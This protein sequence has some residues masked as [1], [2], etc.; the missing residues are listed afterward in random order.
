MTERISETLYLTYSSPIYGGVFP[1]PYA[2]MDPSGK[3]VIT[4]TPT[5]TA[6]G[7]AYFQRLQSITQNKIPPMKVD[8]LSNSPPFDR[9]FS[10]N[11]SLHIR[12]LTPN[13]LSDFDAA[14]SQMLQTLKGN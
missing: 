13:E 11:E 7:Y 14:V 1:N 9:L 3:N 10:A 4:A 2:I 6:L 5:A 8:L 12:P